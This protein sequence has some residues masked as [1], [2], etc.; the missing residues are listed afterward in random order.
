M[1]ERFEVGRKYWNPEYPDNIYVCMYTWRN[2]FN[3]VIKC[4]RTK[5]EFPT[6]PKD[7]SALEEYTPPT[8]IMFNIRK[9]Q[10][11][12]IVVERPDEYRNQL[13]LIGTLRLTFKGNRLEKIEPT[14]INHGLE[15]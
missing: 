3:A 2:G 11:G 4:E 7:F 13:G 6:D 15:I 10:T 5:I 12:A 1:I 9:A 8:Y 14:I